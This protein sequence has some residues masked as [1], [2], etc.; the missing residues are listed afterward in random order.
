M[1]SLRALKSK[2]GV[3]V[4]VILLCTLDLN[5][6]Q[7]S[8]LFYNDTF[9]RTDQHFTNGLSLSWFDD[10][11]RNKADK[12]LTP[13][14]I[15]MFDLVDT[16]TFGS[17]DTSRKHTA[18]IALSQII[19]TP[20][21]LTISTP[22]YDDVPYA[23]Y[24]NLAFYLFEWDDQSFTEYR[25]ETGV[26]G[27]ES[28]AGWTQK[29]IH[30]MVGDTEP[31]GWDTQLGS[32]WI[33]NLLYQKGYKSWIY[34]DSSGFSMDWFN[35]FGFQAGN[36]VIDAFGGTMF[37]VG[38]NYVENFNISSPIL[39]EESASLR[40]YEKHYGFG[41]SF[42]AGVTGEL[43]GYS[44]IIEESQKEGYQFDQNRFNILPY[45][46]ISLYYDE[47]KMTFFYQA[48]AFSLNGEN[49]VDTFGGIRLDFQF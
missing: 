27:K 7:L 3:K 16:L 8:V 36:Y 47:L 18:G 20:S 19:I 31:K 24:L 34:H 43:V 11:F 29:L 39:R 25:I 9:A 13:Y 28:G 10:T 49:E 6:D 32:E 41:W 2:T 4:W 1:R 26:V 35:H 30:K 45:T 21:D 48:H 42:N 37:R 40:P 23:G 44:Y 14:S 12:E 22:Q 15:G 38:K 17:L 46:G 33:V 5:A